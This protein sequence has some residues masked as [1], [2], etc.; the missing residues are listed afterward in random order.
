MIKMRMRDN[1]SK[2][3]IKIIYIINRSIFKS[4]VDKRNGRSMSVKNRI[5]QNF[6]LFKTYKKR[7]MAKPSNMWGAKTTQIRLEK[8]NL[9]EGMA[10]LDKDNNTSKFL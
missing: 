7:R 5:N 6:I 4:L 9:K 2:N 1:H 8:G 10:F 3:F